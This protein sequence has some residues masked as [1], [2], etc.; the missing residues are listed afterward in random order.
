MNIFIIVLCSLLIFDVT[1]LS[2]LK[3]LHYIKNKGDDICH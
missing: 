2:I 1:T 3:I